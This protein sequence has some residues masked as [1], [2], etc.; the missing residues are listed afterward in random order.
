MNYD[1]AK[2]KLLVQ[3]VTANAQRYFLAGADKFP[4]LQCWANEFLEAFA[5]ELDVYAC[6]VF[7]ESVQLARAALKQLDLVGNQTSAIVVPLRM[8]W[9]A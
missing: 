8:N 4:D 1:L 3:E 9:S 5:Y 6:E 2:Q 7:V